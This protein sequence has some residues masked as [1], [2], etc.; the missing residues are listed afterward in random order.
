MSY[1]GSGAVLGAFDQAAW[2]RYQASGATGAWQGPPGGTLEDPNGGI[3]HF[4]ADG[5]QDYYT[6]PAAFQPKTFGGT[7]TVDN[8][9][10]QNPASTFYGWT[11]LE[12]AAFAAI[13]LPVGPWTTLVTDFLRGK[14]APYSEADKAESD[15]RLREFAASSA[16]VQKGLTQTTGAGG[17]SGGGAYTGEQTER[18]A[19]E[20]LARKKAAA[21]D[22]VNR[23]Q[24]ERLRRGW[25]P[26][27][28]EP[29]TWFYPPVDAQILAFIR[30]ASALLDDPPAP[31][32]TA[33][34]T[35]GS[36]NAGQTSSS[37]SGTPDGS[38]A[39][40]NYPAQ[41]TSTAA[42]SS[43]PLVTYRPP[44]ELETHTAPAPSSSRTWLYAG[45]AA[46][47]LGVVI[48]AVASSRKRRG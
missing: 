9:V 12:K 11:E 29:P 20:D 38:S 21:L 45:V 26:A 48:A 10:E 6:P 16:R 46:A 23:W 5:G 15:R 31:A 42:P 30:E 41:T 27:P 47:G 19:A 43:A 8:V 25:P 22:I 18:L 36:S 2:D 37:S 39:A 44:A 14:T 28:K 35:N 24:A 4:D 3:I 13:Q 17:S 40:T 34:Q 1:V 33:G 7:V 32:P